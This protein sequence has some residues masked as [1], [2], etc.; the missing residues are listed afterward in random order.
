MAFSRSHVL[1]VA[2]HC[3]SKGHDDPR[4]LA[5]PG[6]VK[7]KV[8][9]ANDKRATALRSQPQRAHD[10]LAAA[11][12]A[13]IPQRKA[14]RVARRRA[15]HEPSTLRL[16]AFPVVHGDVVRSERCVPSKALGRPRFEIERC[17]SVLVVTPKTERVRGRGCIADETEALPDVVA[18]HFLQVRVRNHEVG[19]RCSDEYGDRRG[20]SGAL[21]NRGGCRLVEQCASRRYRPDYDFGAL[22]RGVAYSDDSKEEAEQCAPGKESKDR[23][24]MVR[25]KPRGGH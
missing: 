3:Q 13:H 22:G 6:C 4:Q 14:L 16:P 7:R 23:H 17:E 1:R 18:P 21:G 8:C 20:V 10:R 19:H 24:H 9:R 2:I 12:Q 11:P 25:S 5:R 15:V